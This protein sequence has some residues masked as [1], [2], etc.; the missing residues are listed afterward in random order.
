MIPVAVAA[1]VVYRCGNS[2]SGITLQSWGIVAREIH[3]RRDAEPREGIE[4]YGNTTSADPVNK[5]YPIDTPRR[6]RAAW[7]YINQPANSRKYTADEVW[8]IEVRI[9]HAARQGP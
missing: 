5:K 8:T 4:K 3:R 2:S 7:A 6:I 1:G 9:R